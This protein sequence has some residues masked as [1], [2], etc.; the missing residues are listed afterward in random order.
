MHALGQCVGVKLNIPSNSIEQYI[1]YINRFLP[2]DI[3]VLHISKVSK[4][5]NAKLACFGRRYHYLIPTY[6]LMDKTEMDAL[7]IREVPPP[8]VINHNDPNMKRDLTIEQINKIKIVNNLK[9]YRISSEKLELISNT[10][11]I[12]EGTRNYH[13]FTYHKGAA[14]ASSNRY[15]ISFKCEEPFI[16]PI[17]QYEWVCLQV[18]GQSFLLNQIR[19]MVAVALEVVRRTIK[20]DTMMDAFS[21]AKVVICYVNIMCVD[22]VDCDW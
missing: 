6:C 2:V 20:V 15:M 9:D 18:E 21:L 16:D 4:A 17:S 22:Y 13:N 5:F 19:K 10:L 1:G 3:R 11:K 12:Y 14:D 7:I 8:S